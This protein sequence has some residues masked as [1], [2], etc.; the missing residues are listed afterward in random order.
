MSLWTTMTVTHC[1]Q[2]RVTAAQ[3]P[4]DLIS[5]T[6][7]FTGLRGIIASSKETKVKD[8]IGLLILYHLITEPS[9]TRGCKLWRSLH[10]TE[11]EH[12][13]KSGVLQLQ[14]L[15]IKSTSCSSARDVGVSSSRCTHSTVDTQ[16]LARWDLVV[17]WTSLLTPPWMHTCNKHQIGVDTRQLP[18]CPPPPPPPPPHVRG[19]W[20]K[21]HAAPQRSHCISLWP[22]CF[23]HCIHY[24]LGKVCKDPA[25]HPR[26]QLTWLHLLHHSLSLPLSGLSSILVVFSTLPPLSLHLWLSLTQL[27]YF[28]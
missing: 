16:W 20:T 4:P 25:Q 11:M 12:L 1:K 15:V 8:R 7:R 27:C 28:L 26:A 5:G 14:A 13:N 9:L 10:R 24:S 3:N 17:A 23:D 2:K 22:L 6:T 19:H 21:S 18:A